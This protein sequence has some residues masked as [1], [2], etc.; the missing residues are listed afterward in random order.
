MKTNKSSCR[1]RGRSL[2][3]LGLALMAL[4][5]CSSS[6]DPQP[7]PEPIQI[8]YSPLAAT[9]PLLA[10]ESRRFDV[11]VNGT[12]DVTVAWT[13]DD[14]PA[15]AGPSYLFDDAT[16]GTHDLVVAVAAGDSSGGR[17]WAVVV[18]PNEI[19]LPPEVTGVT[20]VHGDAPGSVVLRWLKD[21][22]GTYPIADFLVAVSYDDAIDEETWD[23]AD[24]IATVAPGPAI[25]QQ[26][27]MAAPAFDIRP[28]EQVW[29]AVRARDDRG[30]LSHQYLSP[31]IEV[32]TAWHLDLVVQDDRGTGLATALVTYDCGDCSEGTRNAVTGADGSLR[33]GPFRSVDQVVVAT[34][35]SDV[36]GGAA[37]RGWYDYTTDPLPAG[38]PPLAIVLPA[39]HPLDLEDCDGSQN[40]ADFMAYLQEMSRTDAQNPADPDR[41]LLHRWS[42][43]PLTVF[44]RDDVMPQLGDAPIRPSVRD[45]VAAWETA[46]GGGWLVET[47]DSSSADIVVR[48]WDLPANIAGLTSIEPGRPPLGSVVPEQVTLNI[49]SDDIGFP[50]MF[51]V[52]EVAMHEMGHGLG[53]LQHSCLSGQGNLMD[54][55]GLSG[56]L[57]EALDPDQWHTLIHATEI[58]AVRAIRHLPAAVPMGGYETR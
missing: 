38:T 58:D 36:S 9:V 53:L 41:R 51:H 17:A 11:T 57:L 44:I 32:S 40:Y 23:D 34:N 5:A 12:D 8:S 46:M 35:T 42:D 16:V 27:A 20:V 52:A 31:T 33:L 39:R 47:A 13:L 29:F 7:R 19:T 10:G 26:L 15:G 45:A 43:Y 55:G 25:Q 54:G 49:T 30:Q 56:S 3:W 1:P 24:F 21:S 48:V 18:S 4:A 50:N 6:T 28:G 22:T 37:G 14:A 2:L